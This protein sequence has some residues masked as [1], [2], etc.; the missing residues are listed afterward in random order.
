MSDLRFQLVL[1]PSPPES[2]GL[3][4]GDPRSTR[5]TKPSTRITKETFVESLRESLHESLVKVC[6]VIRVKVW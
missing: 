6:L 5:I 2:S 4:F 3:G 1:R